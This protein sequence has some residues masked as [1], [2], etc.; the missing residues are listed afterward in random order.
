MNSS[1]YFLLFLSFFLNQNF[2][3]MEVPKS[4]PFKKL[5]KEELPPILEQLP[6]EIL[7]KIIIILSEEEDLNNII[8]NLS[9]IAQ[10]NT[11]F[12]ELLNDPTLINYI[13][14]KLKKGNPANDLLYALAL[15]PFAGAQKWIQQKLSD[16]TITTNKLSLHLSWLIAS[17]FRGKILAAGFDFDLTPQHAKK[18]LEGIINIGF[19]PNT[20]NSFGDTLL[21]QAIFDKNIP[22]I[23]FLLKVPNINTKNV[24]KGKSALEVA[25][26]YGN[27]QI[28]KM[29]QEYEK[30]KG[31]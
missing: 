30:K 2:Y 22:I 5:Q 3:A 23:E 19:D 1:K 8:Y 15:A 6:P 20:P 28:I 7:E 13:I 31:K 16:G 18:I 24:S 27:F 9:Q 26:K 25:Q 12:R 29:L 4:D 11:Y 10:T 17:Y 21:A 14:Q